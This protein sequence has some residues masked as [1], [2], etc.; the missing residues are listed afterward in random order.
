MIR[1]EDRSRVN[2]DGAW[3]KRAEVRAFRVIEN[4]YVAYDVQLLTI[5]GARLQLWRRYAEFDRLRVQLLRELPEEHLSIPQLP[6]KSSTSGLDNTVFLE[7]RQDGLDYFAKCV[8]MNPFIA[9][10]H[11]IKDFVR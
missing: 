11:A 1:L 4:S 7:T 5:L 2:H 9:C 8:F 6:P 10:S 3:V